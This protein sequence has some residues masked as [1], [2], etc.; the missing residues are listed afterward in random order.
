MN[1]SM[2]GQTDP[3]SVWTI[4]DGP[5]DF[6]DNFVARRSEVID[7][8]VRQTDQVVMA[9]SLALV[10]RHLAR[11]YGVMIIEPR[12]PADDPAVVEAWM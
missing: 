3:I 9:G 11:S 12:L 10:R 5:E 2:T 7:G 6:P 4:Y 1:D 8:E